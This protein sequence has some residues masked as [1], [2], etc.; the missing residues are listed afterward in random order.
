MAIF[1][2]G[3]II[4]RADTGLGEE[5][6]SSSFI[7]PMQTFTSIN[8]FAASMVTRTLC[9]R[10]LVSFLRDT[11]YETSPP[12]TGANKDKWATIY[13]RDTDTGEVLNFYYPAPI[14]SDL[15]TTPAGI[16]VKQSSVVTIVGFINTATDKAYVPLYGTYHQRV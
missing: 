1:D 16:R 13:F 4:W 14:A 5:K 10:Y 9:N 8:T 7:R 6:L 15:E 3:R 2:S 12:G 11:T